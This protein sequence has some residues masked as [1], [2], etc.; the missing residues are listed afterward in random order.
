MERVAGKSV[1]KGI[2]IGTIAVIK[3]ENRE[4]KPTKTTSPETEVQRV[5]KA[6]KEVKELL[7]KLYQKAMDTVD[8][9]AASIFEVH[10]ML[11]DDM[12]YITEINSTIMAE[13]VNAEYA[14]AKAGRK[15]SEMFENM[16]DE[17]MKARALDMKDIT[18]QL[19]KSLNGEGENIFAKEESSII[20]AEELSPSEI[21]RMDKGKVLAF[22][23]IHGSAYSHAAILAKG[24][25]IPMLVGT[26]LCLDK[27]E[28][29]MEAVVDGFAGEF[30]LKPTIKI[31]E[32]AEVKMRVWLSEQEWMKSLKREEN[33]T[34]E[35]KKISICANIS[36]I[37]E[38]DVALAEGVDGIGLFR[39]EFIYIG[40]SDFPTEE[41]QFQV[42]SHVLRR[43]E[44]KKVVIRTLD[45]GADKQADYFQL[46][47]EE[48]PALGL[49]GIRICLTRP[50][51]FKTQLRALFR[52]GV[53]GNLSIMYPMI[54]SPWEMEQ[55]KDI[56]AGTGQ[57]LKVAGIPYK[58]P[59][60]GIMIET[61]AAVMLS[62]EL[63]ELAD[64]FSIGTNDLTQYTLALDRQNESLDLFYDPQHKAVLN[65]I[66][67]VVRQAH[68]A[69]KQVGICGELAAATEFTE[70]FIEM[71]IDELSVVPSLVTALRKKVGEI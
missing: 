20:V 56:V 65:M 45:M 54:T 57:E 64:F 47:Q 32:W 3:K 26:P 14:V 19:I 6:R 31:R 37:A 39:S 23:S 8:K 30:I 24:M 68:K 40:K 69:G 27:L 29:G 60:Q 42:Y 63:A 1:Y 21:L 12:Q 2:V 67:L 17:Y 11:L 5:A 41:E 9:S 50:D 34:R 43:M 59:E 36:K 4:I 71:G 18:E 28:T 61:P 58:I 70:Q 10:G 7:G 52:A 66:Q 13:G 44:G 53:Y 16:A 62:G 38:V 35:G 46:P 15:I 25:G 22:V 48:N 33:D 51:I 49:R 55:I